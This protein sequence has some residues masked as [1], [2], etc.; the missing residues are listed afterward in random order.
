MKSTLFPY[1]YRY[2]GW[3]LLII[4]VISGSIWVFNEYSFDFLDIKV[5][6]IFGNDSISSSANSETSGSIIT[7]I[8]DNFT[9][10]LVALLTLIGSFLVA[11]SKEKI[12]DE[13]FQ[14]LRFESIIWALK[15]QSLLLLFG[16]LFLYNTEF[17]LFMMMA[18]MS[19]FVIYIARYHYQLYKYRKASC[20][21]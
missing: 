1:H 19:F 9:N 13:F 15:C 16:I 3:P 12:E 21:E 10:E 11:F 8:K 4:G 17:L 7:T 5:I 18:L 2:V 14:K 6:S 20:A